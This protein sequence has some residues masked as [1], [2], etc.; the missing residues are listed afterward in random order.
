MRNRNANIILRGASIVLLSGAII[1]AIT[2]LVGYSRQRNFY[3]AGMTVGGVPVGGLSPAEASQRLLEVYTSPVE[4]QYADAIIH[5]DPVL[6]GFE[7]DVESML[8][9]ADLSRTGRP[10]WNGFWDYLWNRAPEG[11]AVPL[12]ASLSEDRLRS[13]LE[14]EIATRYDVPPLPPQPVPGGTSFLPGEPGQTLDLDQAVVLMGDTLRSPSSRSVELPSTRGATARPTLENLEILL[15]QI[16][17]VSEFDGLIGLYMVDLQSGQEIHFAMNE[18][19]E[20][21]VIP[22]IAFT[23]SSTIKIPIVLSY[24]I[25]RGTDLEEDTERD[26]SRVLGQSDN[27]ATDRVLER[28]EPTQGPLIV[29]QDMETLGLDSTFLLGFFFPGAPQLAPDRKTPGNSRADV[30]TDP[31]SYSQTTPSE[32]GSLLTDIYHCAH[33]GGGALV[34]AFPDRIDAEA[35]QLVIDFMA[36]DKLGSLIQGGVPDGTLVPH[37]HGYVP[38]LGGIVHDT[39]DAGIVFSPGGD[40][41]LS[42]YTYHPVQNIWDITNPLFINLTQAIYNYFNLPVT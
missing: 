5:V 3:P 1:L 34:A 9:A 20:I 33:T 13:Y 42:I 29:S 22:D 16:A 37:K 11:E 38:D 2:S 24:F 18:K 25:N 26:I 21:G 40:F 27:T 14:N 7:P 6:V 31:D 32:M 17:T 12:R 28:I 15:K 36:Q 4:V 39:S 30:F 8:A 41:V 19:Q 23:A 10:F 35:C